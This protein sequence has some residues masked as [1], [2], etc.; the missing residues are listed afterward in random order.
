MLKKLFVTTLAG[1]LFT[2]SAIA[3]AQED[4]VITYR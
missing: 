3:T 1:S 4:P 2:M